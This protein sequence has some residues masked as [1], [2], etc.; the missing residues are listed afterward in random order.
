MKKEDSNEKFPSINL[1]SAL[2]KDI[3]T[4]VRQAQVR[5]TLAYGSVL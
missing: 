3:K 5:A 4:R 2:L 1:Y